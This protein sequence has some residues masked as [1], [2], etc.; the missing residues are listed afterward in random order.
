MA[1][2]NSTNNGQPKPS[3]YNY[4][5]IFIL[6]LLIASNVFTIWHYTELQRLTEGLRT[7][8]VNII[9]AY[10][11]LVNTLSQQG[12]IKGQ[13][14]AQAPTQLGNSTAQPIK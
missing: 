7:D 1:I 9:Q 6:G 11:N 12:V 10:N 8:T 13:P 14:Q 5:V 4:F 2:I 3:F